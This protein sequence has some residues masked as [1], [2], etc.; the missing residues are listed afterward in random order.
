MLCCGLGPFG[1]RP[2]S[3]AACCC[4]ADRSRME[5][6]WQVLIQGTAECWQHCNRVQ[7]ASFC[8]CSAVPSISACSSILG[9]LH[10][11]HV[12]R[13][14]LSC[15][16]ACWTTLSGSIKSCTH[17][18]CTGR[19]EYDSS[20]LLGTAHAAVR[21]TCATV[22]PVRWNCTARVCNCTACTCKLCGLPVHLYCMYI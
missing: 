20:H 21:P 5:A 6:I 17:S 10:A 2:L 4:R 11:H 8:S 7:A 1:G 14:Q 22:L 13:L 16:A 12:F 18:T 3:A 19:A 15:K 9:S